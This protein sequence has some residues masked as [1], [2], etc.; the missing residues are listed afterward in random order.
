MATNNE[1]LKTQLQAARPSTPVDVV[2]RNI[3][4][5]FR[6]PENFK[7][8]TAAIGNDRLAKALVIAMLNQI[9]RTPKLAECSLGSLINCLWTSAELGLMPGPMQECAYVPYGQVATFV[10]M[11]QGLVKL[12]HNSGFVSSSTAQVVFENDEFDMMLGS[13]SYVRHRPNW[14]TDR[15]NMIGAYSIIKFIDGGPPA[16]DFMN[17][18][19]INRIKAKSAAAKRSDSPWNDDNGYEEMAKKTVMKRNHKKAPKSSAL[20]RAIE[21]DNAAERPD[22]AKVEKLPIK[23]PELVDLEPKTASAPI[24]HDSPNVSPM[25]SPPMSNT[26]AGQASA[27]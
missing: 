25:D 26:S 6:E 11:Y 20:A 19:D 4:N 3:T 2:T 9:S 14:K 24:D 12:A 1:Q 17:I 16:I 23:M 22:L 27:S 7:K 5:W 15:G 21:L 10:P 18:D 13:E 8:M